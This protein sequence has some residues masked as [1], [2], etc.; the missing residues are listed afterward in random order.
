MQSIVAIAAQVFRTTFKVLVLTGKSGDDPRVVDAGIQIDG[1]SAC[2]HCSVVDGIGYQN[3]GESVFL[4][5]V[6]RHGRQTQHGLRWCRW[7]G[8]CLDVENNV[9]NVSHWK[10]HV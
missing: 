1:S 3:R 6:H 4:V 5:A 2:Q 8:N 10:W 9:L 7:A